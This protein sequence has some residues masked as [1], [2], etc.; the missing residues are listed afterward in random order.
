MAEVTM[1]IPSV[2]DIHKIAM[3]LGQKELKFKTNSL[4]FNYLFISENEFQ[5]FRDGDQPSNYVFEDDELKAS[6]LPDINADEPKD[7]DSFILKGQSAWVTVNNISVY[8]HQD[9]DGVGVDLYPLHRE[10]DEEL[11][12]AFASFQEAQKVINYTD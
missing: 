1:N 12:R 11:D 4:E 10:A 9:P 6:I 5:V 2:L 3:L 8:I 7:G